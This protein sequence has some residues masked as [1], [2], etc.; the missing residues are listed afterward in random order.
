MAGPGGRLTRL[1]VRKGAK[2]TVWYDAVLHDLFGQNALVGF[3]D[4]VWPNREVPCGDARPRPADGDQDDDFEAGDEVEVRVAA[5]ERNPPGWAL[6]TVLQADERVVRVAC[7]SRRPTDSLVFQVGDPA[8]RH[9][10][11]EAPLHPG[12]LARGWAPVSEELRGW[13]ASS[14]ARGCWEQVCAVAG[15]SL[16]APG[17]AAGRRDAGHADAVVLLGTPGAVRRGEMLVKI[18]LMHQQEVEAFQ[19]RRSKKLGQLQEALDKASGTGGT[20]RASFKVI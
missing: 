10:S 8:L 15:L 5:S 14:D 17:S 18:H 4:D 9:A 6:G 3:P 12:A 20:A 2:S 19:R 1:E 16:V 13:A 11:D 7:H